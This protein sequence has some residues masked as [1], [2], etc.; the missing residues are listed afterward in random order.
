MKSR[1]RR[2]RRVIPFPRSRRVIVDVGRVSAR[3][4]TVRGIIEADITLVE[5]A[6]SKHGYSLTAYV[7]ATL[8]RAIAAE[9]EIQA[10]RDWRGRLVVFDSVDVA[11]SIEVT[12]EGRS[13][14]LTH[15]IRGAEQASVEAITAQLEAVKAKPESG[16]T[17]QHQNAA[18]AYLS[19]PGFV[20]RGALRLLYRMPD[21]HKTILGTAGVSSVGMFGAGGG[22]GFAFPVH[23]VDLLVGGIS[24]RLDIVDGA[25]V[26]RR[27]LALTFSFDHDVVDGAPA[28]RFVSGFRQTIESGAAL[29]AH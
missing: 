14:P 1:E 10:I 20:R 21:R 4:P 26:T 12:L 11:V 28:A 18:R 22:W 13:F 6:L 19:L 5:D 7:I 25:S 17:L 8:G 29:G 16:P 2:G 3:R 15:V 27:L 23:P 9:P 24:E